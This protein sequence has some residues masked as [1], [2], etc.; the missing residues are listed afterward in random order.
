MKKLPVLLAVLAAAPCLAVHI[1]SGGGYVAGEGFTL[2]QAIGDARGEHGPDT[3]GQ[4]WLLVKD[5]EIGKLSRAGSSAELSA[6]LATLQ[7]RGAVVYVC[8]SELAAAQLRAAD[9]L[10]GVQVS[11]G[12]SDAE[13]GIDAG[14]AREKAELS[15]FRAVDRL[16]GAAP[17]QG[18]N[19]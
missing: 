10:P 11:R 3:Q 7:Q 19:E 4:F 18:D 9:L 6:S 8:A 13:S 14:A 1:A 5:G 16:C 2:E 17:D 15:P 12:W